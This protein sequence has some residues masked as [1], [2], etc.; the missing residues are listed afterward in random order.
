MANEITYRLT[1]TLAN[2]VLADTFAPGKLQID[3]ATARKYSEVKNVGTS[4]ESVTAFGDISNNGVMY[5]YNLDATN[6]VSVGFSTGV[7]GI[8]LKP[9]GIPAVFNGEPTADLYLL[10][11]TAACDVLITNYEL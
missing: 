8:R 9:G 2:G 10:A 4:E 5:L 7:Y 11:N 3:Q 6:Y 1:L